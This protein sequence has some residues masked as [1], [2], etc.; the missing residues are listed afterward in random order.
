VNNYLTDANENIVLNLQQNVAVGAGSSKSITQAG[1]VT[2]PHLWSKND[3]DLYNVHTTVTVNGVVTDAVDEHTGFRWVSLTANDFTLNGSSHKLRGVAKHEETEYSASA[4]TDADL[5]TDWDNLVDLGVNYVRLPHYPHSALE[6]DLADQRGI[7]IWA[8]N[9]NTNSGAAT[10]NGDTL[11]REMVYQSF[12]HPSIVFWSAGNEVQSGNAVAA[13]G[14]YCGDIK[15]ADPSRYSVYASNGQNP[16]GCNFVFQNTYMGWYAPNM[17]SW[18][19]MGSTLVS[20][21]GAG[22]NIATQTADPWNMSYTVDNYEPEG[23]GDLV[24]EVK[25]QDMFVT[26]PGRV[27]AFSEWVFRDFSDMKYKGY[28]NNKG[29]MTFSNFK[30]DIYYLYQAF[31]KSTPVVHIVGKH[32]FLRNG[33]ADGDGDVKVYSNAPSLTLT[34]N[35]VNKGTV[36]NGNYHHPNGLL[37]NNVFFFST[38]ALS[39]GRND[40]SVAD[41]NGNTDRATVYYKGTANTLSNETGAKVANVTSSNGNS[42]AFYIRTPLH[43]QYPYYVDWDSNGDNTLDVIPSILSGADGFIATHR[44]SDGTKTSNIAFDVTADATV[45]IMFTGQASVPSWITAAGFTDSGTTGQWRNNNLNLVNYQLYQK[46]VTSGTHV[47]LGSSTV[48]YLLVVQ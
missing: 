37:I 48:D 40:L 2:S 13:V 3:P 23:Y 47:S 19:T 5:T 41:G 42:P 38:G 32:Y 18:N 28:R 12:N 34:V 9:G 27:P 44:Q 45:Y 33:D 15:A 39:L 11:T 26:N 4:V 29:L 30:K 1:T 16:T 21:S 46:N 43:D 7:I 8:E 36:N 17:Y 24:N 35:G 14:Q 20:E 6:Y 22:M 10:A 25:Y 31:L